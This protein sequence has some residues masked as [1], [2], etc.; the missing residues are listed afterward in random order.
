MEKFDA[1]KWTPR[2]AQD[3]RTLA[4]WA[5]ALGCGKVQVAHGMLRL[6]GAAGIERSLHLPV[7][8]EVHLESELKHAEWL[9]AAVAGERHEFSRDPQYDLMESRMAQAMESYVRVLLGYA[10]RQTICQEAQY[11]T[12]TIALGSRVFRHSS[13]LKRE[14]GDL[15]LSRVLSRIVEEESRHVR[16]T[17]ALLQS[18][19]RETHGIYRSVRAF[20]EMLFD[21]MIRKL[22]RSLEFYERSALKRPANQTSNQQPLARCV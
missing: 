7:S 22:S 10:E 5:H 15:E 9:Q 8:F 13:E 1:L 11:C 12:A 2:I 19:P 18:L 17:Q 4:A 3:R 14:C 16:T 21:R 6:V 20:E